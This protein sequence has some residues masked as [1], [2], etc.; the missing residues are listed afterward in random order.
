LEDQVV[1][2]ALVV[3]L[4]IQVTMPQ[5]SP[6]ATTVVADPGAPGALAAMLVM[7]ELA[8]LVLLVSEETPVDRLVQLATHWVAR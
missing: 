8:E 6:M 5:Y 2:A 1:L 4:A 3:L 7:E